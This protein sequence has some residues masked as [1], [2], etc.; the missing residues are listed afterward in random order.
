MNTFRISIVVKIT[1]KTI[2]IL[3]IV[4][5]NLKNVEGL[6]INDTKTFSHPILRVGP[7]ADVAQVQSTSVHS[8]LYFI[9]VHEVPIIESTWYAKSVACH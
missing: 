1:C 7:A 2:I 4:W 6:V 8:V 9:S 3:H 5:L